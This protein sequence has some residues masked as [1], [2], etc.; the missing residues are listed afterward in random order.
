[1]ARSPIEVV[2]VG[3]PVLSLLAPDLEPSRVRFTED[4]DVVVEAA[5][6]IEC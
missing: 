6:K 4:I 2:F 5:T 3:G 1:L